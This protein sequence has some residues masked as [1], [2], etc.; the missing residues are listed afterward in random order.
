MKGRNI[1]KGAEWL[2]DE[3]KGLKQ[4]EG[5]DKSHITNDK[6]MRVLKKM[7]NWKHPGPDNV[8]G[9]RLKNL[10]NL[11]PSHEKLVM[12]LQDCLDSGVVPNWSTKG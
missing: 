12:Y 10:K 11:T 4:D 7:T 1:K 3:K 2:K 6:M 9:Y 8:Q 5:Q